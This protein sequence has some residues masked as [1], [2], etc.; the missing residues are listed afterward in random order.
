M[1][2]LSNLTLAQQRISDVVIGPANALK[3]S[4]PYILIG[5]TEFELGC[6]FVLL[7]DFPSTDILYAPLN[8]KMLCDYQ[9]SEQEVGVIL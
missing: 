7:F 5:I 1:K 4:P 8:G 2:T 6:F 3:N 9:G